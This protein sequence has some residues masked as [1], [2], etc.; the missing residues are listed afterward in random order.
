MPLRAGR[1]RGQL[2]IESVTR[3]N[4]HTALRTWWIQLSQLPSARKV[5]WS[6]DVDPVDLY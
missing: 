2:L 4:L 3:R 5:R 1:H 6:I